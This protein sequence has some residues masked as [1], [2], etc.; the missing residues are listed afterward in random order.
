MSPQI[1][2]DLDLYFINPFNF[3]EGVQG[4]MYIPF[5]INPA[6]SLHLACKC[7]D[8]FSYKGLFRCNLYAL[9]VPDK[10]GRAAFILQCL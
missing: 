8:S 5:H 4:N 9:C 7:M 1:S 6:L 10:K 2:F 3:T